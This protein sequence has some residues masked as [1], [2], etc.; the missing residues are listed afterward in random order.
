MSE[1]TPHI[2]ILLVEDREDDAL[3]LILNLEN[4]GYDGNM[5]ARRDP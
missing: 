3:V 2:N 4:A 5:E 1:Q